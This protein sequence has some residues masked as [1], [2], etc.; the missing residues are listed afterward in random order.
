MSTGKILTIILWSGLFINLFLT[1]S[2]LSGMTSFNGFV[3]LNNFALIL[4]IVHLIEFCVFYKRIS[5]A[6]KNPVIGFVLTLVS[7]VLYIKDLKIE[8]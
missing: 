7:G 4:I 6:E 2:V 8:K 3:F 5:A 1:S